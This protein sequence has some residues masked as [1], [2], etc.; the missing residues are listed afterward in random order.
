MLCPVRSVSDE[1]WVLEASTQTVGAQGCRGIWWEALTESVLR[2]L[3]I[4]AKLST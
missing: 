1:E 2:T 4:V 3:L